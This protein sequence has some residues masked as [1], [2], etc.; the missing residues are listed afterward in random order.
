MTAIALV[1]LGPG[2][3]D[4]ELLGLGCGTGQNLGRG[5]KL[6][7]LGTRSFIVLLGTVM[8][9]TAVSG[10][11]ELRLG[12]ARS[13]CRYASAQDFSRGGLNQDHS[14]D[15]QTTERAEMGR[16]AEDSDE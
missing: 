9:F 8:A 10:V 12:I 13:G 3:R 4:P 7:N 15:R 11:L 14:P 2:V 1:L 16:S 5:R 6:M